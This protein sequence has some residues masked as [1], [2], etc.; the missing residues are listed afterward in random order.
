MNLAEHSKLYTH[1]QPWTFLTIVIILLSVLTVVADFGLAAAAEER[2]TLRGRVV[3]GLTGE[4]IPRA[5]LRLTAYGMTAVA[6]DLGVYAFTGVPVGSTTLIATATGYRDYVQ[7]LEVFAGS[8]TVDV[9]LMP[10]ETAQTPTPTPQP[11]QPQTQPQQP[12]YQAPVYQAPVYQAPIYQAPQEQVKKKERYPSVGWFNLGGGVW[13]E[14]R[15]WKFSDTQHEYTQEVSGAYGLAELR[16]GPI[17]GFLDIKGGQV[18]HYEERI[19]G[20]TLKSSVISSQVVGASLGGKLI[21]SLLPGV[22][23]AGLIGGSGDELSYTI[24]APNER[25]WDGKRVNSEFTE[26]KMRSGLFFGGELALRP[27]ARACLSGEFRAYPNLEMQIHQRFDYLQETSTYPYDEIEWQFTPKSA[28]EWRVNLELAPFSWLHFKV[29]YIGSMVTVDNSTRVQVVKITPSSREEYESP[30]DRSVE[31]INTLL[32][33][34][35]LSF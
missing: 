17:A 22:E 29:G 7:N 31:T 9:V 4:A 25:I 23:I 12:V 35:T 32:L 19:P 10:L 24:H 5:R 1:R 13:G 8:Q 34:V 3:D 26:T 27:S 6:D 15:T 28:A 2:G 14:M 21:I 18:G 33:G 11:T 30:M 16:L 20:W